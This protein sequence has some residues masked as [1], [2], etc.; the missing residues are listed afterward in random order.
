MVVAHESL[1]LGLADK[2][3]CG[4]GLWKARIKGGVV[5]GAMRHGGVL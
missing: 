2:A 5:T 4:K 3:E 1:C